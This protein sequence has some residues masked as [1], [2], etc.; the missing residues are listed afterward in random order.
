MSRPRIRGF[1]HRQGVPS[2]LG[3]RDRGCDEYL[4]TCL[5]TTNVDP[6]IAAYACE[7]HDWVA[8]RNRARKASQERRR[9]RDETLKDG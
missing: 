8:T 5:L 2:F 3:C 9:E 7:V 1:H 6:C 4:Q